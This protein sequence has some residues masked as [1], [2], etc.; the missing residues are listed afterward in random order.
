MPS[1]TLSRTS[2]P[3]LTRSGWRA[4]LE[5]THGPLFNALLGSSVLRVGE[6]GVSWCATCDMTTPGWGGPAE[7]VPCLPT[8]DALCAARLPSLNASLVFF[9]SAHARIP[10]DMEAFARDHAAPDTSTAL[11]GLWAA[12]QHSCDG[13]PSNRVLV[14]EQREYAVSLCDLVHGRLDFVLYPQLGELAWRRRDS[15]DFFYSLLWT[16]LVTV[17]VLFLFTRVCEN[18]SHIIRGEG[19]KSDWHTTLLLL[20]ATVCSFPATAR[21]DFAPE[22]RVLTVVLQVYAFFYVFMLLSYSGYA[23]LVE[24]RSGKV[25][26]T[27]ELP[28]LPKDTFNTEPAPAK[29]APADSS[30]NTTGALIAVLLLLTAHLQNTYETPFLSIFVI[31][32]GARSFL[33]FLNLTLQHSRAASALFACFKLAVLLAD[34][35]AFVAVLELAVRTAARSSSQYA[36][37]AAG[38][39][40][41][42]VLGGVFL[43]QVVASRP[44]AAQPAQP[45]QSAP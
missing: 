32:F 45:A 9:P 1:L 42:S 3:F 6:R 18:L 16:A 10:A 14:F 33:K 22:E 25:A 12:V 13:S 4:P 39:E 36:S 44:P 40:L 5:W 7:R 21:N 43:Y 11:G 29:P 17:V 41:L 38:L 19:R 24:R 15:E 27:D 37:T 30:V 23:R 8:P 26:P 20:I 34:T 28:L 35:F 2:F 31:I